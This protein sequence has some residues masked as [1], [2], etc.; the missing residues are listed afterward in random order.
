MS[1]TIEHITSLDRESLIGEM[2]N[3]RG[4]FRLDFTGEYL[5]G[6][7]TDQIRHLLLAAY[8]QMQEPAWCRAAG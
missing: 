8:L 7:S 2:Q 4:R 1:H 6:L 3:F 5:A